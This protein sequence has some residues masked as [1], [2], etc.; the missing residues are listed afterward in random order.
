MTENNAGGQLKFILVGEY[1]V[2][3]D[4]LPIPENMIKLIVARGLDDQTS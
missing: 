3:D 1:W 4:R 2:E